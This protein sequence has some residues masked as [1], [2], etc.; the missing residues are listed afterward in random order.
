MVR[1]SE[2]TSIRD[3]VRSGDAVKIEVDIGGGRMRWRCPGCGKLI[4]IG[5]KQCGVCGARFLRSFGKTVR[6]LLDER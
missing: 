6:V 4:P 5:T 3:G 1:F 2:W